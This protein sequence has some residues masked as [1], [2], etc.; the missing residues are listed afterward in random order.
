[1]ISV[2]HMYCIEI[3]QTLESN[4]VAFQYSLDFIPQA[5]IRAIPIV[6]VI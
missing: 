2:V 6:F 3:K 1:M 4:E 5:V